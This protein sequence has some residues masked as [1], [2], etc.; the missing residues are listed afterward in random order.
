[1][2]VGI[3]NH[4]GVEADVHAHLDFTTVEEL[5]RHIAREVHDQVAQP[6]IGLL[7]EIR[8][9]KAS[10]GGLVGIEESTRA[11]LRHVREMMVD[12]REKADLRINLPRA[13]EDEVPVPSGRHMSIQVTSRWPRE[14]NGWAAFNLLR[15]VQQAVANGWR[16]GRATRIDVVLDVGAS[17]E[18]V[19]VVVDDGVGIDGA[20]YGFGMAGMQER[21]AI[22][23]GT[24]TATQREAGG[25]RVEVRF[26]E[27]RLA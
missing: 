9:H 10:H 27:G 21:A 1:L 11:I 25:T 14:V 6:L 16:H 26:P 15:I 24:L 3:S 8:E 23:G 2:A 12:L 4:T 17:G 18:A 5:R 22:L 20:P 13:L 7:L 19:V